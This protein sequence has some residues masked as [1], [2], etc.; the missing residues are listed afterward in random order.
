[1]AL[2]SVRQ[3]PC[4]LQ[5]LCP[6]QAF[7]SVLQP[8]LPLQ[9]FWPLQ[10]CLSVAAGVAG[11]S[12]AFLP[13]QPFGPPQAFLSF[14]LAAGVLDGAAWPWARALPAKAEPAI[15]PATTADR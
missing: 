5:A 11:L 15:R 7:F 9:A 8:P 13:P 2:P 6:L 3:P 12:A 4:P 10:A 1:M 14:W